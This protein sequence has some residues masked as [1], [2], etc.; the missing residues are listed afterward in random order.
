MALLELPHTSGC[1]VC[2]RGNPHGLHLY[3]NVE[4]T[5]GEVRTTYTPTEHHIGFEG[6]VHG[7]IIATVIDEAMVWAATWSGKRFC[8]CG[9]L[10]VRFRQSAAIGQPVHVIARIE[11]RRSKLI[12]TTCEVTDASGALI[13]TATGKYVPIPADRHAAFVGTFVEDPSTA[14]AAAVLR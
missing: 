4:E 5:T 7:G 2:G 9:D 6:I 12:Q 1:L 10:H 14:R 8:V 11:S 3:L 13:A